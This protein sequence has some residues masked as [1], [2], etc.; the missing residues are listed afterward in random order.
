MLVNWTIENFKSIGRQVTLSLSPITVLVG[1]NSSGK[2]SIIQSILLIKQ[3]LQYAT[4]DR[5]IALNGPLLKLGNYNDVR[6]VL[7]QGEGFR[8]GWKYDSRYLASLFPNLFTPEDIE[9]PYSSYRDSVSTIE[10][11]TQFGVDPTAKTELSLLQPFL[12]SCDMLASGMREEED[13]AAAKLQVHRAG[14]APDEALI[15]RLRPPHVTGNPIY[16]SNLFQCRSGRRGSAYRSASG[17]P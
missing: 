6:N 1:A 14:G 17:V 2:S 10:C 3:T 11:A 8:I 16:D 12:L 15:K 9:L 7:S 13:E 4:P 5:P